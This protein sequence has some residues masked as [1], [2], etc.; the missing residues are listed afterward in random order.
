MNCQMYVYA[1]VQ[2]CLILTIVEV[3]MVEEVT[4]TERQVEM[5][6]PYNCAGITGRSR[7]VKVFLCFTA[8][9]NHRQFKARML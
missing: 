9:N 6:M 2:T 7:N 8:V 5:E 3:N 1:I 4:E